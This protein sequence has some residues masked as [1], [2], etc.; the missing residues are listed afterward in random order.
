MN[1][2]KFL[3]AAYIAT[4]FIHG[5]YLTHLVRSF[6]RLREELKEMSKK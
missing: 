6:K 5:A 3:F 2:I 1:G 4:W